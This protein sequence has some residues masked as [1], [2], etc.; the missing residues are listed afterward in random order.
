ML[1]E[2]VLGEIFVFSVLTF[3]TEKINDF[4]ITTGLSRPL[5]YMG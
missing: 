2:H 5:V 1:K 4:K 3:I